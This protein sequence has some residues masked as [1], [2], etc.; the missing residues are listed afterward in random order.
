MT[1]QLDDSWWV[2]PV[3]AQMTAK[4]VY[5]K[6]NRQPSWKCYWTRGVFIKHTG[7]CSYHKKRTMYE[8]KILE[9]IWENT[10][11]SF[12]ILKKMWNPTLQIFST[13]KLYCTTFNHIHIIHACLLVFSS[14][15]T[16][17]FWTRQF[18]IAVI[19]HGRFCCICCSKHGE[20]SHYTKSDSF[21]VEDYHCK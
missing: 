20:P 10:N 16:P 15:A 18:L 21:T 12:K 3:T 8:K 14:K 6:R 2:R 7:E 9:I 19:C 17:V 1:K 5:P 13:T 11:E 4:S